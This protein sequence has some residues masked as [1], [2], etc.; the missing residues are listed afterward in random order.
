MS[1]EAVPKASADLHHVNPCVDQMRR[2]GVPQGME[3]YR[4]ANA[5]C[6]V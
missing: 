2:M 4:Q 1:T 3:R 6:K 5:A